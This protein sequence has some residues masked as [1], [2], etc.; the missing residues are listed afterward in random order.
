M[1][2]VARGVFH[3]GL[4][5]PMVAIGMVIAAIVIAI[6]VNLE[7]RRSTFRM[8]VLATSCFLR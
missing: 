8:P 4:P 5:L 7:R 3:G 2:S 6:D 1:A